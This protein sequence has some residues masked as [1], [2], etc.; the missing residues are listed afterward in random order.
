MTAKLQIALIGAGLIGRAHLTRI[1]SSADCEL[2]AIC[3]PSEA[4]Q[5]LAAERGARWFPSQ[6]E[7]LAL[8]KPDGA[9]T[10]T[11]NALHVPGAVDCLEA[12]V[13]VLVE[14]PLAES[15]AAAQRLVEAQARTGIA[16]LAGH[17]R[18]HNPIV[19]EAR[20]IV[21]SGEIGR[22]VAV[23]ALFLIKKPDDYFDVAWR[24]EPGGGPVLINLIHDI[25][26]LR[27]ICGEID[28]VQAMASNATRGFPVEDTAALIFRFA[29]G[30]LGT[31]T[32]SD[33]T[34]SPWSWELSSGE[35]TAYPQREGHCYLIAG[36]EGSLSLPKLEH[37]HHEGRAGWWE[38]LSQADRSVAP[39]EPLAEQLRHFCAVIRG[40][41]QPI[42]S[43]AD[44]A[45][46]LAVVEAVAEAARTGGTVALSEAAAPGT[47][48]RP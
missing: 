48:H 26:N 13:P 11:P 34:P 5:A 37:W 41:E 4:A 27:F 19:K 47:Q 20:R 23:N 31:A 3:D 40:T 12:G 2:A 35:N 18:R 1:E 33:A 25:D 43:A 14:K 46:T 36:S 21:Q 7:M 29:N 45:R 6:R 16:V 8:I 15:V 38:P 17:H 10:A 42:T 9:I 22:L 30:A 28:S 24:R 32:V 44:A 39:V